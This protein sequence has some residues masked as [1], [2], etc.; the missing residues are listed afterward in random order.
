MYLSL[1]TNSLTVINIS[2][3][4]IPVQKIGLRILIV[5]D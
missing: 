2:S 3:D 5:I 1:V 4:E